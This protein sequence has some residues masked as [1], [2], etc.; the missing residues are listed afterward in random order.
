MGTRSV[1]LLRCSLEASGRIRLA[2]AENDPLPAPARARI[3]HQM[4]VDVLAA[5]GFRIEVTGRIPAGP[6]V[7]VA[8]HVSYLDPLVVMGLLP[9]LPLAKSEVRHWPVIGGVASATGVAFIRRGNTMSGALALRVMI[10]ILRAG[11]SVLNFPEGTTTTGNTL[12]P[13][14]RGVFGVA[15]IAGVPVIPVTIQYE[16]ESLSWTG[17]AHFLPHYL[18]TAARERS[19]VRV[20]LGSA[21]QPEPGIADGQLAA[22]AAARIA[23]VLRVAPARAPMV[24]PVA[25]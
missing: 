3:L 23:A 18:Q 16:T 1:A 8:N 17:G 4:S 14:R 20:H 10:R 24:P 2:A 12:L 9:C 22:R 19:W 6:S 25:A 15:R 13:F 5:H 21:L 11:G 7:L